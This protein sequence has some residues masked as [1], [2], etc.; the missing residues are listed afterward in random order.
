MSLSAIKKNFSKSIREN[1]EVFALTDQLRRRKPPF[2]CLETLRDYAGVFERRGT[3][4][5]DWKP[6]H[7]I[8]KGPFLFEYAETHPKS[9]TTDIIPLTA[10][11]VSSP[12]K[13]K[14]A[15]AGADLHLI[16]SIRSDYTGK[17]FLRA[18]TRS[19][20]RT[21]ME[22]LGHA[23]EINHLTY[24]DGLFVQLMPRLYNKKDLMRL[25]TISKAKSN[26][27][28]QIEYDWTFYLDT[29]MN[30][31]SLTNVLTVAEDKK[32][33]EIEERIER[34][35][36]QRRK[37]LADDMRLVR[38]QKEW[39]DAFLSPMGCIYEYQGKEYYWDGEALIIK[40]EGSKDVR[41]RWDG[42]SCIMNN[43]SVEWDGQLL[44]WKNRRG[45]VLMSF[46]SYVDIPDDF[47][48]DDVSPPGSEDEMTPEE[49]RT[50][51]LTGTLSDLSELSESE[52]EEACDIVYRQR[53][54]I[55]KDSMIESLPRTKLYMRFTEE[56]TARSGE[57][58]LM[59]EF[60]P[61]TSMFT[62]SHGGAPFQIR[63]KGYIPPP[64]LLISVT[65]EIALERARPKKSRL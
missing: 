57:S 30:L 1:H 32:K 9:Q 36:E 10:S 58:L 23:V 22:I 25:K 47:E 20:V 60:K 39:K 42:A 40:K 16:I 48:L 29:D 62:L 49:L 50:S 33:R 53:R 21:W 41:V 63:F 3:E 45:E 19:E 38:L 12:V 6:F 55:T 17:I 37:N 28:T 59:Y 4:V 2:F 35:T 31:K 26:M 24:T 54:F 44:K 34:N 14:E 46:T 15:E 13:P 56:K 11:V 64:L 61:T 7:Y 43:L 27:G 52:L 8:L 18:K 5:D 51:E 65:S